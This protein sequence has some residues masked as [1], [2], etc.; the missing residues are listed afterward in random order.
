[1]LLLF[2]VCLASQLAI[3]NWAMSFF[4][5]LGWRAIY[6]QKTEESAINFKG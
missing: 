5:S 2:F 3:V 6:E 4:I 1:M